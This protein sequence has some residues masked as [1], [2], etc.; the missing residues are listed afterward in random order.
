M[1]ILNPTIE[2]MGMEIREPVTSATDL[3]T[4]VVSL[5]SFILLTLTKS[6][7]PVVYLMRGYF[8]FMSISMAFA[9]LMGHAFQG[10]VSWEW[11]MVGWSF[12][13]LAICMLEQSSI[14]LFEG[15]FGQNTL[16]FLRIYSIL[17]L[18]V[19]FIVIAIPESRSFSA[20]KINSTVGLIGM[21]LPLHLYHFYKTRS[22]GSKWIIIAMIWALI[23]AYTFNMEVSYSRWFNFHDISHV[24]MSI[25]TFFLY[26][27]ARNFVGSSEN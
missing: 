14:R 18:I 13:A 15:T 20:V 3:L 21:V 23:P 19:F 1:E 4:G 5:I 27:G 7:N 9:G 24:L 12:G 26:M 2:W 6:K 22:T 8:L 10:Y 16:R 11:K 17:H 25:Y